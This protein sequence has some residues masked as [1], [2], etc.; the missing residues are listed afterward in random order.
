MGMMSKRPERMIGALGGEVGGSG[1]FFGC[2]ASEAGFSAVDIDLGTPLAIRPPTH[3]EKRT[4][5]ASATALILQILRAG[6]LPEVRQSVVFAVAVDVV[7]VI[8]RPVAMDVEPREPMSPVYAPVYADLDIAID[9]GCTSDT[10]QMYVLVP[11]Y[12]PSK[13]AGFWVVVKKFAQAVCAKIGLS[14]EA[15]LSLIGQRPVTIRSRVRASLFS[16]VH[17][18]SAMVYS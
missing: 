14:H 16:P 18:Y 6:C 17:L 8:G 4:C 15:V 7:Y 13:H 2:E 11:A 12:P 5:A 10:L 1:R 3:T 9:V